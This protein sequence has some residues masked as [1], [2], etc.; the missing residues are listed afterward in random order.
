M[1]HLDLSF[2]NPEFL[3]PYWK[4]QENVMPIIGSTNGI[5]YEKDGGQKNLI[6][7]IKNL[8]EKIG[9]AVVN[10]KFI[11]I[12]NG[13]TQILYATIS[14]FRGQKISLRHPYYF[15][16]PGVIAQ[17]GALMAEKNEKAN[18]EIV[19][20]PHNPLNINFPPLQDN[21]NVYIYDLCYNWPEYGDVILKDEDIMIYNLSKS[22]GHAASRIGWVIC[23]NEHDA[24]KIREAIELTT[25]GV[26]HE[27]QI[28]ATSIIKNQTELYNKNTEEDKSVFGYGRKELEY[29]WNILL[30]LNVPGLSFIN[31]FGMFALCEYE[32]PKTEFIGSDP[33]FKNFNIQTV[34]GHQ[35]GGTPSQLRINVGCKREDFDN[36]IKNLNNIFI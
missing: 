34:S 27:A 28:R 30:N 9:N 20:Q 23:K 25:G 1:Q 11:V 10:N 4:T 32:C 2:G 12:G 17:A 36:L 35:C 19:V 16:F 15:K 29:R 5:R 8:H 18:V 31:N 13:A 26:S 24:L 6:E 7:S 21:A 33:F 22:T 14:L 3:E